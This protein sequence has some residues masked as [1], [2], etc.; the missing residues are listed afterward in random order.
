MEEWEEWRDQQDLIGKM[1]RDRKEATEAR[2][3]RLQ[4][5]GRQIPPPRV[6]G[7]HT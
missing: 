2:N 3:R 4:E 7:A 1:E 5:E 6:N